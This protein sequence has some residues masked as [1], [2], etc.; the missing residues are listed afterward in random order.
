M[1]R[2]DFLPFQMYPLILSTG[3]T[4]GETDKALFYNPPSHMLDE[5]SGELSCLPTDFVHT[6]SLS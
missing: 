5:S 2:A 1:E 3:R 4:N 6:T